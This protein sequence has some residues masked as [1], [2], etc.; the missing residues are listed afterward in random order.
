MT[1]SGG[2]SKMVNEL[3]KKLSRRQDKD[4]LIHKNIL[5]VDEQVS[6]TIIQAKIALEKEKEKDVLNRRLARRPSK[7]D[8]KLRNILRVDSNEEL[9]PQRDLSSFEEQREKVKSILKY[10][11]EK[12]D[13]E[14][15][16]ILKEAF[17]DPSLAGI[18][19]KLKRAQ[20]E[21]SLDIKLR[22]RPSDSDPL[23]KKAL[24]F[25][26]T[27]EILPT[28]RKTEYNRKPDGNSTF[29]KLTPQMK[30]QIRE[31]LNSFKKHEMTV[32]EQ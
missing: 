27:V 29:R 24:N 12:S 18:Q 25:N 2:I 21:N 5:K 30:V 6:P 8:L 13:L 32:H 16:N 10:R 3:G 9:D 19:E 23:V 11:P 28:F 26:E 20:L 4:E 17:I 14:Q 7:V 31:E 15:L 1:D 22:D